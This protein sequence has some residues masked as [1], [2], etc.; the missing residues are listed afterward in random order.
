MGDGGV[1]VTSPLAQ[2]GALQEDLRNLHR[3]QEHRLEGRQ[4]AKTVRKPIIS[5]EKI[6]RNGWS[7]CVGNEEAL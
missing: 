1:Q 5:V 4:R 2:R 3:L 6:L 7:P